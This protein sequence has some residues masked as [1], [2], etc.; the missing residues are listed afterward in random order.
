MH[1]PDKNAGSFEAFLKFFSKLA[2]SKVSISVFA[3]YAFVTQYNN[4]GCYKNEIK[5]VMNHESLT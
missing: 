2:F 4:H 5:K 3:G 1:Q